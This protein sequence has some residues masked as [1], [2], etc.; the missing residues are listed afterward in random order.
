MLMLFLSTINGT[1][2]TC[3][4][5]Y[6]FLHSTASV[7]LPMC[8]IVC[9]PY[10]HEKIAKFEFYNVETEALICRSILRMASY[11]QAYLRFQLYLKMSLD[12]IGYEVKIQ[13]LL[14]VLARLQ[15]I[16]IY[17]LWL[18]YENWSG[19]IFYLGEKIHSIIVL[20]F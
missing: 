9:L 19:Y 11:T 20:I 1:T 4:I 10:S 12:C 3:G 14:A 8:S 17:C 15:L 2:V 6:S 13:Q 5:H 18:Y 16:F 7:N